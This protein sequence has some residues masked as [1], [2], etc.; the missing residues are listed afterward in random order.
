MEG[1]TGR[2]KK[3]GAAWWLCVV[4]LALSV[5]CGPKSPTEYPDGGGPVGEGGRPVVKAEAMEPFVKAMEV[6][7]S[8]PQQA[9][10]LLAQAVKA[11]NK[12]GEAYYNIGLLHHR[13]GKVKEAAEAY[14]KARQLRPDM[15]EPLVNLGMLAIE[16]GDFAKAK[17][18]FLK[19]V[20][21][22]K[23]LDPFNVPAN[24]NLGML[25]RIAGEEKI[26]RHN[27][28]KDMGGQIGME[29]VEE[30]SFTV[31]EAARQDFAEAVRYVRKALAG[32]SNNIFCYENLAAIYYML[33]NLDVATL[34][35]QQA[36][37][38]QI[39]R[40]AELDLY[41]EEGRITQQEYELRRISDAQMSSVYNT[42]G[43]V[44]L[45]RGEVALA[46]HWFKE[47]VA[48]KPDSIVAMLNVAGV[49]VN[50]QDYATAYEMYQN[51]LQVE[52][53]NKEA[54]LS[55]AVAARGL[56]NLEE[57]ER[58]YRGMLDAD[59][60]FAPALFNLAILYQEYHRDLEEAKRIFESFIAMPSAREMVPVNVVEAEQRVKQ[61]VDIW[62][63][64][65]KAEEDRRQIEAEMEEMKR[66]Q[67]ERRRQQ[68]AREKEEGSEG[69]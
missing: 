45:A 55:K 56:G 63:A 41:L 48:A 30:R 66:L 14:E 49:A 33:N 8:N 22:E 36:I 58:I 60:D 61:I 65:R 40:N 16:A 20:D 47:A 53:D 11:D 19:V 29:G 37:Q 15:A 32:D 64:Q 51:A 54:M 46:Y 57:A 27:E 38:K 2:M 52:P 17:E 50:V 10:E 39:E 1:V 13:E 12:F 25:Y 3:T 31:D 18:Y 62:E 68:E 28:G 7:H 5:G 43:L 59:K 69:E 9:K 26:A 35:S 44:W 6:I 67:E 21:D 34:V 42:Y 23:G 24:L 4:A